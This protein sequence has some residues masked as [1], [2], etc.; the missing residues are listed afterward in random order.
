M[1]KEAE[2]MEIEKELSSLYE[3]TFALEDELNSIIFEE[4]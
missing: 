4:D 1:E 2:K 3:R